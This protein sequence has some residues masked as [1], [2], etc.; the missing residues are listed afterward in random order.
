MGVLS[1]LE[2]QKVFEY[3]EAICGI[4]HGS[5][6][7]EQISNYLVAFARERGLRYYQD[8]LQNVIMIKEA[9]AGYENE[10]PIIL[11]GHM[12][13]VA[14]KRP[15]L[16]RD[17]RTQGLELAVDGDWVFAKGTSL[18]G[19]N[20]AAVALGLALLDSQDIAHP[21]LEVIFTVDEETGMEGAAG[22]DLSMLQANR[23]LNLDG[24][25]SRFVISCAGGARVY[26]YMP[27]ETDSKEGFL[28][29]ISVEGLLGGHSGEEIHKGRG[30]SN[31]LM[32]R[33][34]YQLT[35]EVP[36][37]I[38]GMQGG[39]AD[40]AISRKTEVSVVVRAEDADKL[41]EVLKSIERE[42]QTE[43]G[44]KD[45]DMKIL[46]NRGAKG[47]HG[48]VNEE[49]AA[50]LIAYLHA[51]PNGVQAMSGEM[52]G[53]VETSLNLG[54]LHLDE[55]EK[56]MVCQFSVRSSIDSAKG[57]LIDKLKALTELAGGTCSISGIY[58]GW[59]YRAQSSLREKAMRVYEAAYGRK[60]EIQAIH[61]GLECG[62][63]AAKIQELDCISFG[64]ELRDIHTTEERLSISSVKRVW[65]YLI[66]LLAEK[67]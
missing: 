11:Q 37:Y 62:I 40:N 31:C 8:A 24:E 15:E 36:V 50:R 22:I 12:D 6:N 7:M 52:P 28:Y 32:G 1:A 3:F 42:I 45:P 56:K 66:N 53:L 41:E 39:L 64:P 25:E 19:D 34:L 58:P 10:P 54:V 14:V 46:V 59:P 48:C 23:M 44:S 30:N 33:V 13:M 67:G 18:G 63:F 17:M 20:G 16:D 65:E 4:P 2:P 55:E 61:A 5:G 49:S 9:A 60:P 43:L 27:Y 47:A 26:T 35:R 29:Q 21:R 57:A 51:L 38:Q